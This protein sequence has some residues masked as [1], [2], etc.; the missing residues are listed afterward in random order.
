[1]AVGNKKRHVSKLPRHPTKLDALGESL[2]QIG[3]APPSCA[4]TSTSS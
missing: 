4:A 3:K 2:F 1:M